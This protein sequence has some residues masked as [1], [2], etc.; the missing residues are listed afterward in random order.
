MGRRAVAPFGHNL[1]GFIMGTQR[2]MSIDGT[3]KESAAERA[4]PSRRLRAQRAP[5]GVRGFVA[6]TPLLAR[7]HGGP[8][9]AMTLGERLLA[10]THKMGRQAA[11][12]SGG[13]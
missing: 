11:P 7:T 2:P 8:L 3:L 6:A 9:L 5:H 4:L 1:L 10:T 13:W 12:G